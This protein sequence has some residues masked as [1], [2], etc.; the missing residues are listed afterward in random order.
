M[1][2]FFLEKDELDS[3]SFS[4]NYKSNRFHGKRLHNGEMLDYKAK[5]LLFI[6]F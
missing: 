5:V 4:F 2:F 3:F 1:N 6:Y